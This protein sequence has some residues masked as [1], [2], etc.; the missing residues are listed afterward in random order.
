VQTPCV[1]NHFRDDAFRFSM[2]A[3][4]DCTFANRQ[5]ICTNCGPRFVVENNRLAIIFASDSGAY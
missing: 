2:M 1:F 4:T 5:R 3:E